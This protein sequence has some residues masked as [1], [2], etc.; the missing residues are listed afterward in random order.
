MRSKIA[1]PIVR[2]R[3]VAAAISETLQDDK[4]KKELGDWAHKTLL[5]VEAWAV[6]F[7]T[8][9]KTTINETLLQLFIMTE[10]PDYELSDE[11]LRMMAERLEQLDQMRDSS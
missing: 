9:H 10:G 4:T 5:R 6:Y 3:D 8:T 7:E 1:E 2:V 11:E